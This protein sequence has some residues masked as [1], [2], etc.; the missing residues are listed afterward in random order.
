MEEDPL[1]ILGWMDTRGANLGVSQ[2][3]HAS[4]RRVDWLGRRLGVGVGS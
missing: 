2:W 3:G 1:S 4:A